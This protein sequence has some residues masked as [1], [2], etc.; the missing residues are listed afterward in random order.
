MSAMMG[1]PRNA[2]LSIW[3]MSEG[4]RNAERPV[5]RLAQQDCIFRPDGLELRFC[6]SRGERLA[7]AADEPGPGGVEPCH[8][9]KIKDDLPGTA[10][11]G[12]QSLG[13]GFDCGRIESPAAFQLEPDAIHQ[14][15]A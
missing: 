10:A 14:A 2:M 8:L 9:R 5:T 12:S 4:A 11:L 3:K 1:A 13:L 15:L 7:N 6:A